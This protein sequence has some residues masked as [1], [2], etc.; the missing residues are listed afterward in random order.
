M[1]PRVHAQVQNSRFIHTPHHCQS[2]ISIKGRRNNK[3]YIY[4]SLITKPSEKMASCSGS[5]TST[6]LKSCI[7]KN[8][9]SIASNISW[10]HQNKALISS[11]F[12]FFC[13][14]TYLLIFFLVW[15]VTCA[16]LQTPSPSEWIWLLQA[17]CKSI[18]TE[19][20][21]NFVKYMF[22]EHVKE[23]PTTVIIPSSV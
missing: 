16:V 9:F 5:I 2:C 11:F 10:H 22:S 6:T 19:L 13:V 3:K 15:F 17:C 18:Q 21:Q 14:S 20:S 7:A 1:D 12:F 8:N 23:L 4:A